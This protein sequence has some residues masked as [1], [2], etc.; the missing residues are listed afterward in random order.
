MQ[1]TTTGAKAFTGISTSVAKKAVITKKATQ[2]PK[3]SVFLSK[4]HS[5]DGEMMKM[6]KLQDMKRAA[7]ASS[8]KSEKPGKGK[9]TGEAKETEKKSEEKKISPLEQMYI[10]R[11]KNQQKMYEQ[12][13]KYINS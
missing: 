5:D 8:S 4:G 12:W 13:E 9:D 11:A 3:D 7:T 10:D 2:G 1:L 6:K